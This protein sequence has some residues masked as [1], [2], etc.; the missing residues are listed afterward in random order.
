[1]IG[2][3]AGEKQDGERARE[4][5]PGARAGPRGEE[6]GHAERCRHRHRREVIER[7]GVPIHVQP[8]RAAGVGSRPAAGNGGRHRPPERPP[9]TDDGNREEHE[10]RALRDLQAVREV[11]GVRADEEL[12][13]A[14]EGPASTTAT[15]PL[16]GP[17]DRLSRA[18]GPPTRAGVVALT[19][20]EGGVT[21]MPL[22]GRRR[23][24][25]ALQ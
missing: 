12:E 8:T 20:R 15:S 22:E 9:C 4:P 16:V 5:G 21:S 13:E 10:A 6:Q 23:N 11:G 25:A 24:D 19:A 7:G 2:K 14:P 18:G 3:D 17:S 1:M